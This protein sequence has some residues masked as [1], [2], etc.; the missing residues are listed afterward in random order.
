MPSDKKVISLKK[1]YSSFFSTRRDI[2]EPED[3]MEGIYL[4]LEEFM[5]NPEETDPV[6]SMDANMLQK[7]S[8]NK[9]RVIK[10]YESWKDHWD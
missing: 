8:E 6:L 9:I 7:M 4:S 3:S 1:K 10:K 5:S 2:P